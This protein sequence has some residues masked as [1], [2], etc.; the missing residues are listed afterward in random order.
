MKKLLS[1]VAILMVAALLLPSIGEAG[2]R[3]SFTCIT[4]SDGFSKGHYAPAHRPFPRTGSGSIVSPFAERW[5]ALVT[6]SGVF[7]SEST[8]EI[9]QYRI[10]NQVSAIN[11]TGNI[12][13][14]RR[15]IL[16]DPTGVISY[17]DPSWSYDGKYLAYVK[18]NNFLTESSIYVQQY[19]VST[20]SGTAV[21]PV[22]APILVV[23]GTG[24]IHPRHPS[25]KPNGLQ[26]AYDSD[27]TGLSID[28]YTVD[29]DPV[30]HTVGFPFRHT[31]ND[32]KAEFKP[33][34][35]PDGTKLAY[36][37]NLYGPF[38]IAIL[39]LADDSFVPAE[40]AFASVSHDN[41]SWSSDGASIYYDAPRGEDPANP[42]D[43]FKLDLA[44]QAK[45]AINLDGAGDADADVSN[46]MNAA[47]D[48]YP[49]NELLMVSSAFASS[50][51]AVNIW[52]A[53]FIFN[54]LPPLPFTVDI[55]PSTLTIGDSVHGSKEIQATYHMPPET[56]AA[57]YWAL[58]DQSPGALEGI[59]VRRTFFASPTLNGLVARNPPSGPLSN[60]GLPDYT[61]HPGS[62]PHMDVRW[63]RRTFEARCVALGQVDKLVPMLSTGYS[64]IRGRKFVGYGYLYVSSGNLAGSAVRLEQNYPNPFNPQTKINFSVSKPGNVDVRVFNVR[65]ELVKTLTNQ[66][67]AMGMHTI[68]WDGMTENGKKTSSGVYYIRANT[69]GAA[70]DVIKAVLAQ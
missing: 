45:C 55:T 48:G 53:N 1:V 33:E 17:I 4:N 39:T 12:L 42:T 64:A 7:G 63:A 9:W 69:P 23:D 62:D 8:G 51:G 10:S 6:F 22:G 57:G 65:G 54:C 27:A 68:S 34:Y 35:S 11:A 47:A 30:A 32:S 70:P 25:W 41:P 60:S 59:K 16:Q 66:N 3:A 31:T 44:T 14:A 24:G 43:I 37:T 29:V 52:K 18:T 15:P 40:T 50:F 5:M 19:N 56:T 36:V 13:D 58:S 26:L 38:V 46:A 28:L 2:Y 67:Y 49:Y 61:D 20:S 21:T